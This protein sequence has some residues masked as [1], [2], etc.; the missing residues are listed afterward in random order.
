MVAPDLCARPAAGELVLRVRGTQRDGQVVRLHA[1]KCSIGADPRCTLRLRAGGVRPVHCLVLR[2]RGGAIVRRWAADTRLNGRAFGESPLRPGD[3]LTVGPVELE[4]VGT[5][6]MGLPEPSPAENWRSVPVPEPSAA[7]MPAPSAPTAAPPA[8]PLDAAAAERFAEKARFVRRQGHSRVRRLVTGLRAGRQ[9]VERTQA[10]AKA[11]CE[12]ADALRREQAGNR[13]ELAAIREALDSQRC[14]FDAQRQ[15][16]E[17]QAAETRARLATLGDELDSCRIELATARAAAAKHLHELETLQAAGATAARDEPADETPAVEE[18]APASSDAA[19]VDL[20]AILRRYG[21]TATDDEPDAHGAPP[22]GNAH[23]PDV[24]ESA[25][26]TGSRA[27]D[28]Q[29][30]PATP[31]TATPAEPHHEGD[32]ESIDSYMSRLLSRVRG[33]AAAPPP[34]HAR[35]VE[36]PKPTAEPV[37]ADDDA[38]AGLRIP[39]PS[40]APPQETELAPR[41][42][43]PERQSGLAAMRELA[44]LSTFNALSTHARGRLRRVQRSKLWTMLFSAAVGAGLLW[45]WYEWEGGEYALYGGL[46]C[47]AVAVLWGVRYAVVTGRLMIGRRGAGHRTAVPRDK[48][49]EAA[50]LPPPDLMQLAAQPAAGETAPA[51]DG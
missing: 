38:P 9:A 12:A 1:D 8:I 7:P 17:T 42:V 26:R 16:W 22:Q 30:P 49:W 44:N 10:E 14:D 45:F 43:A 32:E 13:D 47:L 48:T 6:A 19:P 4:V 50:Q 24:D 35:P 2:G 41:A 39:Q 15:H 28:G 3:R 34:R 36:P 33:E 11:A 46:A 21:H 18:P 27:A 25:A 40:G 23:V 37:A 29:A 5:G 31:L 20:E 51:A